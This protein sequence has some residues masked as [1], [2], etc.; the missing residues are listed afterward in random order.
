MKFRATFFAGALALVLSGCGTSHVIDKEAEQPEIGITAAAQPDSQAVEKINTLFGMTPVV[1]QAKEAAIAQCLQAQ[2]LAWEIRPSSGS[3]DIRSDLSPKPL[4]VEEA[5]EHGYQALSANPEQTL[6]DID[7]AAWAAYMGNSDKGS[8]SVEGI[9]GSIA[10][11][12]CLAQSYE[13]VF[14]S[15]EAGVLFESGISNLPLSY[16]NA[17]T[18]D[19]RITELDKQWS[20]CMKN[21]HNVD[22]ATPD[23]ASIDTSM[24]SHQ[25]AIYDAQCRQTVKYEEVTTDVLNAYMTTFLAD[26]EGII[27]Q[28]TRAKQTAEKNAPA[29]LNS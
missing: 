15:A 28:L 10:A 18:Q 7:D 13:A 20:T 2:G 11:D 16:L 26:Q 25:L 19:S 4:S 24:D 12:G 14:G 9:S 27:D 17:A 6:P 29:I 22:I 3:Y 21:Q 23:L 8:V 5:Q 1:Q